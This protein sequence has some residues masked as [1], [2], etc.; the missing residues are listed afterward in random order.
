MRLLGCPLFQ[1]ASGCV[2][3]SKSP[4]FCTIQVIPLFHTGP[5]AA[6]QGCILRSPEQQGRPTHNFRF[7]RFLLERSWLRSSNFF[8][9]L[10]K[11]CTNLYMDLYIYDALREANRGKEKAKGASWFRYIKSNLETYD[12]CDAWNGK[13]N[14]S[15]VGFALFHGTFDYAVAQVGLK[16]GNGNLQFEQCSLGIQSHCLA[17]PIFTDPKYQFWIVWKQNKKK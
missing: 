5:Y 16:S 4:K 2:S 15:F 1:R 11:W 13:D 7:L 8:N 17:V 14:G 12:R 6:W 10:G 3:S 9:L